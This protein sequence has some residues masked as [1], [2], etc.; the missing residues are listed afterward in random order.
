MFVIKAISKNI[1][2]RRGAFGTE[3][4][5]TT[6]L[7]NNLDPNLHFPHVS[8]VI[9]SI[10]RGITLKTHSFFLYKSIDTPLLWKKYWFFFFLS[11]NDLPSRI[12]IIKKKYLWGLKKYFFEYFTNIYK[13]SDTLQERKGENNM[14]IF[15]SDNMYIYFLNLLKQIIQ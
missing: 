5:L 1:Y 6:Q 14:N 13:W 3:T 8:I 4:V 11:Q 2:T 9:S 7:Y 15:Q 10:Q 12:C